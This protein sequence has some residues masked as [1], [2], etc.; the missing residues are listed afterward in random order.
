M[1]KTKHIGVTT[2]CAGSCCLRVD[3]LSVSLGG[4][5]ILSDVS[6]HLHC[7]EQIALIGPN[8]AGKSSLFKSILGQMPHSGSI[9]FQTAQ[10]RA[11]KPRIGYVPQ[12][13]SFDPS[14]PVSVL[15][16]FICAGSNWPVWLPVPKKLREQVLVC[17]ARVHGEELIDRR[18]GAL[19]GGELQRV[20]LA[21]AL[22]P[23]PNILI[24]DEPMSGVD[25]EGEQQLFA[26]LDDIRTRY[27]LS[28]LLSTHDFGTLQ[29]EDKVILLKQQILKVGTP[30]EVLE[31]DQFRQLFSIHRQ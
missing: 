8:G 21:M 7:G 9:T 10:G 14:D 5:Q 27:D 29:L 11:M 4:D 2:G 3:K 28:I 30:Q 6:F 22:E 17:L 13:P 19:S 25:M 23:L 26:L 12:S 18:V 15:D 31:S 1:K 16:L 24:L 20:L